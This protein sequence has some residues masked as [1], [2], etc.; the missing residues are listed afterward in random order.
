[1]RWGLAR[2]VFT[3]ATVVCVAAGGGVLR[4]LDDPNLATKLVAAPTWVYV[5]VQLA[6]AGTLLERRR[7]PCT[8]AL[9]IAV[10]SVFAPTPAAFLVPYAVARYGTHA[11]RSWA[12]MAALVAGWV[13]GARV[14]A[15]D[16]PF[17]GLALIAVSAVLG[18][19]VR[20]RRRLIDELVERAERAERERDLLAERARAEERMRLAGEMHD[21]VTHRINLMVL[22][23]GALQ[24]SSGEPAVQRAS[25]E[26]R[27]TGVQ[28]L[29][30]LR[31]LI[32]VLR[33]GPPAGGPSSERLSAA[34]GRTGPG[35]PQ[36]ANGPADAGRLTA[37]DGN[38]GA[39]ASPAA[40]GS[41][42]VGRPLT[43]GRS[44]GTGRS[45]APDG[46][47]VAELI[48]QSRAVGLAV[49]LRE[50][51]DPEPITPAVRRALYRVVQESLTNVHKHA[52][53][54]TARVEIRYT[55]ERVAV[56]VHN[57][58]PTEPTDAALTAAGGGIGLAGLRRRVEMLGGLLHATSRDDGG[59]TVTATLPAP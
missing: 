11:A 4:E 33:H 40:D 23:A 21:L 42:G 54:C 17:S 35:R 50:T 9:L 24:V 51:G 44:A 1:M 45:S 12:V 57:T 32:G 53:G 48:T 15:I 46:P 16:D 14:W 7:H 58:A 55:S 30:E 29:E 26:L 38:A 6:A 8:A 5:V 49:Q 39:R 59:F 37:T 56:E 18:L 47:P 34:G 52:P 10:A 13:V 31:D 36:I 28:A 20:A 22:Q 25:G 3:D 2:R 43:A 41:A 27:E 19:Y